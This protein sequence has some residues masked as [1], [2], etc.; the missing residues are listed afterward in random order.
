[1]PAIMITPDITINGHTDGAPTISIPDANGVT[2]GQLTVAETDGPIAGSFTITAPAGLGSVS[3]GGT[4][5][6]AAQLAARAEVFRK[7]DYGRY[8]RAL[9]K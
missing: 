4:P 3:L 9:V 5:F 1:M 7:N 8:L 6:T 2:P